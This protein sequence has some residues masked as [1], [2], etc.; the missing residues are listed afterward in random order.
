MNR[1][2]CRY[3]LVLLLGMVL[4][5]CA[6]APPQATV[7]VFTLPAQLAAGATYRYERLPLQAARPDQPALE[8]AADGVLARAGL[9][10]D[11]ANPRLAVQITVSQD[12]VAYA[13]VAGPSWMSVGVGGSSWGGGS[14]GGVGIGFNFP[15]GGTAA[16]YPALRVDVIMRDQASG[17]VVFQSQATSA[18]GANPAMLLEAATRGFPNV[19]P[20]V[21]V[22]PLPVPARS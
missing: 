11:D 19:P 4:A 3:S 17:Q 7:Q 13:P 18:S 8:A 6:A 22:V 1:L 20:G 10:R 12:A 21:R 9:R 5:G 2:P 16:A 15:I 14:G